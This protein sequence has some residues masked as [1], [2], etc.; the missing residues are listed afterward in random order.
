MLAHLQPMM[1][2]LALELSPTSQ[3]SKGN[4]VF[5]ICSH[6]VSYASP[7]TFAKQTFCIH[8]LDLQL[9]LVGLLQALNTQCPEQVQA[10]SVGLSQEQLAV[11]TRA[12]Q[13]Q[14]TAA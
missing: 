1:R 7:F 9:Q 2:V 14:Q 8:I 4:K 3:L 13:G 6:L 10:A 12:L 5:R 11:L